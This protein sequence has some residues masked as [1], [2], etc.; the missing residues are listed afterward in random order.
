MP[1]ELSLDELE[2]SADISAILYELETDLFEDE[3][4]E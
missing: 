2:D 1:K 4:D 3:P